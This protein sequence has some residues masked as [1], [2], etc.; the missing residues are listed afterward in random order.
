M[1]LCCIIRSDTNTYLLLLASTGVAT[2][3]QLA[4]EDHLVL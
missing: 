1:A 4:T 2:G 3:A